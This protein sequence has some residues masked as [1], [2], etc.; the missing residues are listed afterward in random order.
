MSKKISYAPNR[1][2]SYGEDEIKAVENCLRSG[3]IAGNGPMTA[4]FEQKISKYFGK[5][6]GI[7]VNSGSSANL[8]ALSSLNLSKD[9]EVITPACTFSTT[10]APIIQCGAKPVFIDIGK[11]L[12]YVADI[13]DVIAKINDKTRVIMLPNLIGSK[14]DWKSLRKYINENK[15]NII[16]IED[17]A[18]TMTCTEYTD[19]STTSFYASHLITAC[20]SGG[21]T[22]YNDKKI[23]NI[24]M[25]YRDWG[26]MG[27]NSERVDDR[28][29]NKVDNVVYDWKFIYSVI[30]YNFKS[31]EVN[32]AF[33]L[34]Q[35]DRLEDIKKKRRLLFERYIDNLKDCCIIRLPDD[36]NKDDWL[37][38]PLMVVCD[39][40][41]LMK[42]LESNNIQTRVC[43]SGNITKHDAYLQY[44]ETFKYSDEVMKS[45]M[46]LG[47]HHGMDLDDVDYVCKKIMEYDMIYA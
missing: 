36:T 6:Y 29:N 16:L 34:V 45:G 37:A 14:P 27:D 42:H 7:F 2:E 8:L 17:S 30:G 22:M 43:F 26:R 32:A 12:N 18:D 11:R 20:G 23:Y 3:W 35:F 15:L 9:D 24:G 5:K 39:R 33:G 46:L 31:S 28:F 47:C 40:T 10:V 19:I 25:Q 4:E 1:F 21:M 41:E 44:S 13:K 38:I